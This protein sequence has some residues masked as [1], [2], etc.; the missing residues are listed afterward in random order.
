MRVG[1]LLAPIAAHALCNALSVPRISLMA[2]QAGGRWWPVLGA[3][4]VGV[5]LFAV[6]LGPL[7]Q[8]EWYGNAGSVL[9]HPTL[10]QR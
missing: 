6:L 3:S 9:L 5:A 7:T 8:P 2:R 1:S 4:A 10:V